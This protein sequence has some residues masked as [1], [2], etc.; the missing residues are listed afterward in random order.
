MEAPSGLR[1]PLP[2][3]DADTGAAAAA[4]RDA[5]DT[6]RICRICYEGGG[7]LISPCL[8]SG[9]L[10]HVHERCLRKWITTQINDGATGND[11]LRCE[12]C[13]SPYKLMPNTISR[14]NYRK[15]YCRRLSNCA[16]HVAR[17]SLSFY[18]HLLSIGFLSGSVSLAVVEQVRYD[19]YSADIP[20]LRSRMGSQFLR[21]ARLAAGRRT[22]CQ[23]IASCQGL[24]RCPP[25]R[26]P[27]LPLRGL[28][29][30][31][32]A[33]A[34]EL[35][36]GPDRVLGTVQ[37]PFFQPSEL[38]PRFHIAAW[39]VRQICLVFCHAAAAMLLLLL[40][41]LLLRTMMTMMRRSFARC[42]SRI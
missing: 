16:R 42:L 15:L 25:R 9:S 30:A 38:V 40:L 12:M 39:S 28:A 33:A 4:K 19:A 41:L 27:G 37:H 21:L 10:A 20:F 7:K 8:C 35:F 11:P 3:K 29:A 22:A 2:L 34:A 26:H 5:A 13:R 24:G 17:E 14:R 23:P 36:Q 32:R 1:A 18:L 31:C 6:K